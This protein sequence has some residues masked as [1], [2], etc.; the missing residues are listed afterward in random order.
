MAASSLMPDTFP[1]HK[2][3]LP[4]VFGFSK[5]FTAA[6]QHRP[7]S[8]SWFLIIVRKHAGLNLRLAMNSACAF[9]GAYDSSTCYTTSADGEVLIW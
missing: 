4:Y 8:A 2:A 9:L 5:T 7:P 6:Y 3:R 1:I